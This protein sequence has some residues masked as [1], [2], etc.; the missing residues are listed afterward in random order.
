MFT[1][2]DLYNTRA[3]QEELLAMMKDI[4]DFF[5]REK[6]VYS[7][8][9]GSLLGAVR[10]KGF[11]PWDDDM[12][13]M[14]DRHNFERI[15]SAFSGCKGYTLQRDLWVYRIR[16]E[17]QERASGYQPTVDIFVL[18]N[19]PKN[20]LSWKCKVLR[21]KILQ[22]MMKKKPEY[23]KYS[24][25][26]KLMVATTRCM[27]LFFTDNFKWKRY[28]KISQIGNKTPTKHKA[29]Y[30]DL[31]KYLSVRY[32]ANIMDKLQMHA[33]EDT[34]FYITEKYDHCLKTLYGD[35]MTPPP[36]EERISAH[37]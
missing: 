3:T 31:Y 23:G 8:T 32:D 36:K 5:E 20:K 21:L 10:E 7:L 6:I 35:Y 26:Q 9:S 24:F 19:V 13:I 17:T 22:G 4:H 12:D 16:R 30:N 29:M 27:G 34:Q 28:N 25:I 1:N 15:L 14:V 33:F 18:D 37:L 2:E 11:I